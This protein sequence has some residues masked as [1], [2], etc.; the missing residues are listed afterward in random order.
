[1]R[2]AGPGSRCLVVAERSVDAILLALVTRRLRLLPALL[3]SALV[4][5]Q[6]GDDQVKGEAQPELPPE[7][8]LPPSPPLA[9]EQELATIRVQDGLVV[10]LVAAEPLIHDPVV[11]T[12]DEAGRLWVVEMRGFMPNVDGEGELE[13]NGRIVVLT[14]RDGD[15]RMDESKVFLDRLVLPRAV[16]PCHGGALVIAPPRILFCKEGAEPLEVD[17]GIDAGLVN[18]EHAA[19]GLLWGLDNWI[20]LAAHPWRYRL[21]EG[22]WVRERSF[23]GGQWGLAHDDFGRRFYDYNSD[24]L[25][26]DLL[27]SHYAVHNQ[28]LEHPAFVNVRIERDQSVWPIRITPTVNRAYRKDFLRD[29]RLA[30]F[31][32]AC[33][34]LVYR[35]GALPALRGSIFICE[36]SAQLVRR[37]VVTEKDGMLSA[38]N[39][40]ERAEFLAATDERFRPVNLSNGPDGALYVVDMYR[41]LIQH[42][43]FVTTFLRKQVLA[44]QLEKPTGLGRIWRIVPKDFQRPPPLPLDGMPGAELVA[45]LAHENGW[46]RDTAQRLLVE[47]GDQAVLPALRELLASAQDPRAR[48]HALWTLEGLG[49]LTPELLAAAAADPHA[50]VRAAAIRLAEGTPA[51]EGMR[52]LGKDPAAL[53]RGQLAL[54]LGDAADAKAGSLLVQLLAADGETAWLRDAVVCGLRG[55]ELDVLRQCLGLAELETESRGRRA[56]LHTLARCVASGGTPAQRSTLLAEAAQVGGW[57]RSALLQGVQAVLPRGEGAKGMLHVAEVPRAFALL[58][59][60]GEPGLRPLVAAILAACRTPDQDAGKL[61]PLTRAQEERLT[62]GETLYS[63]QCSA[64]HQPNGSG[65]HGI[66]PPLA[67]SEW[68]LGNKEVLMR[69]VLHGIQGPLVV[70]GQSFEQHMPGQPM[71]SDEQIAAVLSY[72]RREWGHQA[73]LVEPGEVQAVRRSQ[74]ARQQPWTQ[75]ELE[76]LR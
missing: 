24:V 44:R 55:R 1:V 21:R 27:P 15:G 71:L 73:S 13:P 64:C 19:N 29:G 22:K 48:L 18:P 43:N 72:V 28:A 38:R 75:A 58:A 54:S 23:A 2:K 66:S 45:R 52:V 41:G 11:A 10:E 9:P 76:G 59:E 68:V 69:I 12:F 53:V 8:A 35:G 74:A 56:L 36:P 46:V 49:G 32:A 25:R 51:F 57:Q 40:Y 3:L 47:R 6:K 50:Q 70:K 4:T 14:D 63:T 33:G 5:A 26:A 62:L 65:I 42:K 7:L 17:R 39:A 67:G 34:P 20:Y 30:E 16:L 60:S 61:A 31:T 37:E